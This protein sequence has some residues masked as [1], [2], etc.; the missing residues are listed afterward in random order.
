MSLSLGAIASCTPIF[1]SKMT[2]PKGQK[3]IPKRVQE[4]T[5]EVQEAI[6][7]IRVTTLGL[8]KCINAN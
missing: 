6:S 5:W 8:L 3:H 4:V 2:N 7:L 1:P